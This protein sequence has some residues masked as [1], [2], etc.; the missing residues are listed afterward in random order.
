MFGIKIQS[1]IKECSECSY[2]IDDR[3]ISSSGMVF[4]IW[5]DGKTNS[6]KINISGRNSDFSEHY[7]VKCP[8][9]LSNVWFDELATISFPSIVEGTYDELKKSTAFSVPKFKDYCAVLDEG[10]V[11]AEHEYA[12]R[13]VMWWAG[14]DRRRGVRRKKPLLDEEIENLQILDNMSDH[15]R[16]EKAEIKRELGLFDEASELLSEPFGDRYKDELRLFIQAL[17][18]KQDCVVREHNH[19]VIFM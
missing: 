10:R 9:C 11:S 4:N 5:T 14:N 12:F 16:L 6:R 8:L 1:N 7:L 2:L 17:V 18:S 19:R 15:S 3:E 13:Q